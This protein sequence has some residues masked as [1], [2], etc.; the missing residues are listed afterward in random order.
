MA[1]LSGV[2]LTSRIDEML[3]KSGSILNI[4]ELHAATN[5]MLFKDIVGVA[6]YMLI[7]SVIVLL[8][9]YAFALW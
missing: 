2:T 6:G 7:A 4:Q 8:L 1:A 9:V 5:K 3:D